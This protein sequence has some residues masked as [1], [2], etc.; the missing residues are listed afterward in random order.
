MGL[1]EKQSVFISLARG[2][3]NI[4]GSSFCPREGSVSFGCE[5]IPF[6]V[7]SIIHLHLMNLM[8]FFSAEQVVNVRSTERNLFVLTRFI[9][10]A[11]CQQGAA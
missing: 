3:A 11:H 5:E 4:F 7:T 1:T 2:A 6:C 8:G 9:R 10:L